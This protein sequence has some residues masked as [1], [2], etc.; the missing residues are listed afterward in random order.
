MK[1]S[2]VICFAPLVLLFWRWPWY[3][4][5]AITTSS[6]PSSHMY[7]EQNNW[8][9]LLHMAE[10]TYNNHHHPS[11]G[12]SPFRANMGYDMDMM[13]HGLTW[14]T[15]TPLWLADLKR[16]QELCKVWLEKAQRTQEQQYNGKHVD[17][18]LLKEGDLMWLSSRDI[19]TNCLS[20]KLDALQCGLLP[21]QGVMGPLSYQI[22]IP[23]HWRV[24]NMFHWSKL[25]LVPPDQIPNWENPMGPCVTA[26]DRVIN[27][28]PEQLIPNN[29]PCPQPWQHQ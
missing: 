3:W 27:L 26:Q 8:A 29:N 12:M 10:F 20:L 5:T 2:R 14:G 25:H 6:A 17:A 13:G 18:P 19:S 22:G 16:L 4:C 24:H 11:I 15:D 23:R 7:H 9:D 1:L 21:V 28:N